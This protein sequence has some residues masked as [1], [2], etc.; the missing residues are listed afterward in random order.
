MSAFA[1][2]GPFCHTGKDG[3]IKKSASIAGKKANSE[4]LL[5]QL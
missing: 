3:I 2:P 4:A 1:Y 5:N